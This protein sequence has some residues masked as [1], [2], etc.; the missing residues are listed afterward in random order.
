MNNEN[1]FRIKNKITL[2]PTRNDDL[3]NEPL[4]HEHIAA[5]NSLQHIRDGQEMRVESPLHFAIA[6]TLQRN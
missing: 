2:A 6:H 3:F 1:Q 5:I 4:D